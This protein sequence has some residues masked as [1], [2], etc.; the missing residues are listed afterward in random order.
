MTDVELKAI[1]SIFQCQP[2]LVHLEIVYNEIGDAGLEILAKTVFK[3]NKQIKAVVLNN[4]L[5]GASPGAR[6]SMVTFLESF[7]LELDKPETLDLSCNQI[8]D[9]CLRPIVKYLFANWD[10]HIHE[11]NLEFNRLSNY[12]KRTIAQAHIRCPNQALKVQYGPLPLTQANLHVACELNS[13]TKKGPEAACVKTSFQQH[14]VVQVTIK[15]KPALPEQGLR[16]LPI[17]KA[18][19]DQLHKMKQRIEFMCLPDQAKRVFTEEVRDFV[20]E[21]TRLEFEFPRHLMEPLFHLIN[22]KLETAIHNEDIYNL[23]LLLDSLA[24]MHARNQRAEKCYARLAEKASKVAVN[25]MK[26]I[27]ME[28]H[29]DNELLK[30]LVDNLAEAKKIGMRGEVIDIATTLKALCTKLLQE[31]LQKTSNS[32]DEDDPTQ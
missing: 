13:H 15:R 30:V 3:D 23:E 11:L 17:M 10:C 18:E 9:D 12:A 8:S 6:E 31:M 25:L 20:K 2:K 7:L 4:N 21:L 14:D 22:E 29:N 24:M 16:Y 26:A 32:D 5:I 28:I 27:N 19:T 1:S